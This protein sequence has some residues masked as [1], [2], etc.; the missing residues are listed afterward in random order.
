MKN[1]ELWSREIDWKILIFAGAFCSLA[2]AALVGSALPPPIPFR[3][4]PLLGGLLTT[5][6]LVFVWSLFHLVRPERYSRKWAVAEAIVIPVVWGLFVGALAVWF[7]GLNAAWHID[8]ERIA[9]QIA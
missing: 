1:I 4:T 9:Q 3:Q 2:L 7:S 8:Y 5:A 6:L